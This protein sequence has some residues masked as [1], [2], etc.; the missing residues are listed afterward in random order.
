V[1]LGGDRPRV[2]G[3]TSP[4]NLEF[5]R[6]LNVCDDVR[7]YEEIGALDAATPAAFVDMAG[8]AEV[9]AA[10]HKRFGA[11]LKLSSGVGATHW[12]APRFRGEGA[13]VPHNFFF[14]PAQFMKREQ[15]WGPG[16]VMRRASRD[17]TRMSLELE[18]VLKVQE[19]KGAAAVAACFS[20]LVR[21]EVP[22]DVAIVANLAP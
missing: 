5:V 9:I 2:I 13:V 4:R 8:N 16:E 17:S 21:N 22:A 14:A 15:E 11:N 19:E 3:L 7:T 20:R 12:E 18:G 6:K 1:R 10:I